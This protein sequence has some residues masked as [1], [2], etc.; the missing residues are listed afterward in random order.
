MVI[1]KIFVLKAL[2]GCPQTPI[3]GQLLPSNSLQTRVLL[4]EHR[5]VALILG[6]YP[7]TLMR[8]IG[9]KSPSIDFQQSR[10]VCIPQ[11]KAGEGL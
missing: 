3:E 5:A 10:D 11:P 9:G 7:R 6:L 2:W 8:G 1:V 4:I